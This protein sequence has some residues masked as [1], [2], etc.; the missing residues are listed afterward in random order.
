[1][2]TAYLLGVPLAWAVLLLFHPN[3]DPG[4]IYGSLHHEVDRWL[5]VHLGTLVFIGLL[6]AA[7]FVLLAH[8]TGMAARVSRV[9]AGVFVLFYGAG[10]AILGVAVG[11][12]VR[13]GDR[14]GA[15]V[16]WDDF[17]TDDLVVTVGA[18]GWVVAVLAAA[19]ALRQAGAPLAASVLVA[20]SAI[21]VLHGPP[22]GPLGLVLFAAGVAIGSPRPLGR[23]SPTSPA[24]PPW[25]GRPSAASP[26]C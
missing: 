5:A 9:G 26:G 12:L 14:A 1:L 6:G 25:P 2:R 16:L 22:V 4:D 10:E 11:V 3:P 24:E 17:V 23:R 19:V 20:A 15:Q 8:R 18:I 21:V 7:V 13:N